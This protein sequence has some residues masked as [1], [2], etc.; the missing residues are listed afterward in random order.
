[1]VNGEQPVF[2]GCFYF[3]EN[4]PDEL[5]KSRLEYSRQLYEHHPSL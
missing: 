5:K 2:T 1:M 3:V 4:L